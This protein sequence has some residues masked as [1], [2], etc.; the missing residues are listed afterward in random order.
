M[1]DNNDLHF[2]QLALAEARKALAHEDIPVG[3]VLVK[4][5]QVLAVGRNERELLN[6]PAGHAEIQALTAGGK[7]NGHWNLTGTTLYVTLEP[8]VMCAGALVLSR[9]EEVVYAATDPKGGALSLNIP[10]LQN[11]SLNHRV[12]FRQGPCAEEAS[13]LLKDFF[14]GKRQKKTPGSE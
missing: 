9:V 2:M 4:A 5:G 10:I 13:L 6:S 1:P 3:A 11:P 12:K 7:T 14:R 8:C